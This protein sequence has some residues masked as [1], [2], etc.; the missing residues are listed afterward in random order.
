M[1]PKL[2]LLLLI[3]LVSTLLIQAQT[4]NGVLRMNEFRNPPRRQIIQIPDV[5]GYQALK[6]DLHMHT[7]FSDG[8]VWPSVRVQEAL[9]RSAA[10][11]NLRL[12]SHSPYR[13]NGLFPL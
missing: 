5:Y 12:Y 6:C 9:P 2:K 3:I 11:R 1:M 7:I 8:H 13:G 10:C 4:D